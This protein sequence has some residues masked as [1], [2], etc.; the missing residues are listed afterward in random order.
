MSDRGPELG[1]PVAVLGNLARLRA[2][3]AGLHGVHLHEQVLDAPFAD[4]WETV[5][6]LEGTAP[7]YESDVRSLRIVEQEGE[8]WKI[9]VRMPLWALG[10]PLDLDVTMRDGW[11]WMVTRPQLYVVGLAAEPLGDRTL[12]GHMEGLAVSGRVP[13]VLQPVMRPVLALSKA[14]HRLH[15]PR[16]VHRL[17]GLVE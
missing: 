11:C 17:A 1:W 4:V 15:V 2:L 6:D 12:F 8:R 14:R 9:K 13:A 5:S 7:R 3:A 10:A 16:D